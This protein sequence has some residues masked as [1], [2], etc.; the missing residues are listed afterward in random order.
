MNDPRIILG[1]ITAVNGTTPGPA[2]GITYTIVVSD[3]AT[4]GTFP[5]EGQVPYSRWPDELDIVALVPGVPVLGAAIGGEITWHFWEQPAFADCPAGL[6]EQQRIA[7]LR[8]DGLAAL[9]PTSGP[10]TGSGTI[11][12]PDGFPVP[13]SEM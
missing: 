10:N 8:G 2:S 1:V 6:T 5:M 13:P 3:P 12:N 7:M 9:I 11:G 4:A